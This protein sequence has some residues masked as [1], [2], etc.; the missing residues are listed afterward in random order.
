MQYEPQRGARA[1]YTL[2]AF[3]F[4]LPQAVIKWLE[5]KDASDPLLALSDI[6]AHSCGR[7]YY[8]EAAAGTLRNGDSWGERKQTSD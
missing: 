2:S 1:A 7:G 5:Q 4:T 3:P 8:I 6:G